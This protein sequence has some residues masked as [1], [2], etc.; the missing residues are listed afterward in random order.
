MVIE[1]S[2][3]AWA[4]TPA[5]LTDDG[6]I[7]GRPEGFEIT[8]SDIKIKTGSRFIVAY[9]NKVLTMPGLPK[10]PNALDIDV[11]ENDNIINLF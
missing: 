2:Q 8:V 11:D 1:I 10:H 6:K 7:K 9:L 3:F 4:K 5:S